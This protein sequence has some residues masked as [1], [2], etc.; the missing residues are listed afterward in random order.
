[1]CGLRKR[2]VI[3]KITK[4]SGRE[5][6]KRRWRQKEVQLKESLVE[7]WKAQTTENY[8]FKTKEKP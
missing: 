1:M 5:R 3:S 6:G 7:S 8:R 4:T 2:V